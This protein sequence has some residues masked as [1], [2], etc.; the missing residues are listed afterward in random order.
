V[1]EHTSWAADP[2]TTL[3]D[4]WDPGADDTLLRNYV[5]GFAD[6]C[7]DLAELVGGRVERD[8]TVVLADAGSPAPYLNGAVILRP[9]AT[10]EV[11]RVVE[12]AARFFAARE[13]GAWLLFSALPLPRLEHLGL[14][15]IGHP[16]FM[17]RA[18]GAPRREPPADLEVVEVRDE[19]GL[20]EME[21][22]LR[23]FYPMPE[24][25]GQPPGSTLRPALL[26]NPDYRWLLGLVDGKPV[27]TAMAHR[28][29]HSVHVE[30]IT[31]DPARR[32]KGYGEAMTWEAT[33]AWPDLPATLIASD[34]GRPTYERM[35]YL[36]V[37]RVTLW[38]GTR[39][40]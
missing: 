7:A 19:V 21:T 31:S 32:G 2:G 33:L 8:E 14:A 13:G 6:M 10:D 16:P 12:R 15:P 25:I 22:A 35:G 24:L 26:S 11:D 28:K 27:G 39:Q 1:S 29:A 38:A 34:A 18:F 30:W 36:S 40:A 37:L 23:D 9:L 3:A 17:I 20:L 5:D 4:G